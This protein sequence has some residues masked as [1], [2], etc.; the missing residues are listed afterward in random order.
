MFN[1]VGKRIPR[2]DGVG[3]VTGRTR[4]I[5]D[6][7][8]P[9]MLVVKALRS[10]VARGNILGL[11][12]SRAE[13]I[14]GVAAILTHK[15]VPFNRFGLV[16]DQPV[17]A[18]NEVRYVGQPIAA[19]A[20]VDEDT[21][22]EALAAIEIEIEELP[23]VFDPFVAMQ[24]DAPRV[25]AEGNL[26]VF[27]GGSPYRKMR[28]GDVEAALQEADLIVEGTYRTATN[29]HVPMETQCAI[30]EVDPGGHVTVYTVSQDHY[31][32]LGQL[33]GVL[34]MPLNKVRFVGGTVGG[35][36][37]AKNDM[38]AEPICALL[39]LKSGR[40]VKWRWTREEEMLY[41]TFR[42]WWQFDFKD[43]VKKNGRIIARQIRTVHD[44]GGYSS[45]G[46]YVVDKNAFLVAGPYFIPNIWIDGYCVYTNKPPASSMRGFGIINGNFAH[47]V[48]MDRVAEVLGMDPW[49]VRFINAWREGEHTVT[50]K[51]LN[52]VGVIETMQA[53]AGLA[54][55]PLPDRLLS[56]KSIDRR[57]ES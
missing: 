28:L 32:H 49:E 38:H 35:G 48:Q 37:G 36:F 46:P 10:P 44:S 55:V 6:I 40:P 39:A 20:A 8:L 42:G 22:L 52:A 21:A 54:G 15:D 31:F 43:G 53:L 9:G 23:P 13:R 18:E 4:Y 25:R 51:V 17:L 45:L 41:S 30:G 56:L 57:D 3:H 29:E 33:A 24:P 47:E 11:N 12:V 26:Y 16:P 5:D 34:Q 1:V 2:Y 19:V 27:P 50:K 7:R 14:P